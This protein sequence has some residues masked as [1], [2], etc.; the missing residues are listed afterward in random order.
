MQSRSKPFEDL[1]NFITNA[2]GALKG[3][4]DEVKAMTRSQAEK[5]IADMDL[6]SRDEHEVL[7]ARLDKAL[8]EIEALKAAKPATA[9]RSAQKKPA[10]KKS[11]AKK[12]PST[13]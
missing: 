7:K 13:K 3:V 5:F 9:K 6:V 12:T 1:S 11:A 4:G 8:A 2:A 10:A